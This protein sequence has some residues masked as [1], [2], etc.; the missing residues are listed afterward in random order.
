MRK[1]VSLQPESA[2]NYLWLAM[3][4]MLRGNHRVAVQLARQETDPF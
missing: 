1:T 2:Q 3:I 4:Q